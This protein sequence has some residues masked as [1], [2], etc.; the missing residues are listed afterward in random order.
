[1]NKMDEDMKYRRYQMNICEVK[2]YTVYKEL[3]WGFNVAMS[4]CMPV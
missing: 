4:V 3:T 2:M 1:M